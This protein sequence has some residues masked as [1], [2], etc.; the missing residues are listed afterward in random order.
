M[1]P[2]DTTTAVDKSGWPGAPSV[3]VHTFADNWSDPNSGGCEYSFTFP[4]FTRPSSWNNEDAPSDPILER[5]NLEILRAYGFASPS[6]TSVLNPDEVGAE[7]IDMCKTDLADISKELGPEA[8]ANMNYAEDSSFTVQL[9]TS[10]IASISIDTYE[11]TGGAHGNPG[12]MGVTLDMATGQKLMLGN[13]VKNDQLQS[14]MKRAYAEILRDYEDALY[15]EARTEI[16]AI[17]NDT[18][19]MTP[20]AQ[21]EKFGNQNF[22][23]SGDGLML[24]WNVYDITPYVAGQQMVFIPWSDLEGKLLVKRP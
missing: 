21:V 10:H 2:S 24:F 14:I 20:E 6:G 3:S 18:T 8:I 4:E 13:V 1:K 5:A 7:F 15:E 17:V 9:L 12:M 23:L 11:Y 22:F 19:T 16:N